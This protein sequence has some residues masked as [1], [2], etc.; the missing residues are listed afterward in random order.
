MS[1]F[2]IKHENPKVEDRA[3]K[4]FAQFMTLGERTGIQ[5]QKGVGRQETK[6]EFGAKAI[7]EKGPMSSFQFN[8]E[9]AKE[10]AGFTNPKTFDNYVT[11]IRDFSLHVAIERPD[12]GIDV[13]KEIGKPVVD[14]WLQHRIDLGNKFGDYKNASSAVTHIQAVINKQAEMTGNDRRVNFEKVQEKNMAVAKV[15]LERD[16]ASRAY[17]KPQEIIDKLEK[18]EHQLV[19]SI[20]F[21]AGARI[22]EA[23]L[24]DGRRLGGLVHVRGQEMGA[25]NLQR[26]DA[27]GGLERTIHLPRET[28]LRVEAYVREN[29]K[30]HL[31]GDS[32]KN[33][34]RSAIKDAALATGQ[35]YTG[36]HGLRHNYA[37]SRMEQELS[38]GSD[39]RDALS[40]ISR[41][42]GHFRPDI[43]EHYLK[44]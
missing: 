8:H 40:D 24:I 43:T 34:Y 1:K 27:K 10:G 39:R 32:Q 41:E 38:A 5:F 11:F 29:G 13:A 3:N 44:G 37:Q 16:V 25:I 6:A 35:K 21:E 20:Q 18:V 7:E 31:E 23:S 15:T 42:M 14:R 9:V 19:A 26:G 36:S 30:L 2:R 28:Y 17:E 22:N 4:V 33:A 12:K